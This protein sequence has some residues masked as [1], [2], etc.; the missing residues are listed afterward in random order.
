MPLLGL[1]QLGSEPTVVLD[2]EA[3]VSGTRRHM[4]HPRNLLMV[5][6]PTK[7]GS[8]Q[9]GLSIDEAMEVFRPP[10][11]HLKC[12]NE[13]PSVPWSTFHTES[14]ESIRLIHVERLCTE[15]GSA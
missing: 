2:L 4:G 11:G 15:E 13:D 10:E 6:V 8:V 7:D 9:V 3:I 14:G 12:E 1:A 5:S